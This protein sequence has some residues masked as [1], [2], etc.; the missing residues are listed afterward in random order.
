MI[1]NHHYRSNYEKQLQS[2]CKELKGD[3]V[4]T[5]NINLLSDKSLLFRIQ[6][7]LLKLGLC[8]FS[9]YEINS[10]KLK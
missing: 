7:C 4:C 2:L 8:P 3:E 9:E 1:T 10:I 6:Y 5:E